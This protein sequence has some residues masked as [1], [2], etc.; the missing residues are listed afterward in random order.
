MAS[1]GQAYELSRVSFAINQVLAKCD[2]VSEAADVESPAKVHAAI[3]RALA[4]L[5]N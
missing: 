3:R 1:G 2:V 4:R 5:E